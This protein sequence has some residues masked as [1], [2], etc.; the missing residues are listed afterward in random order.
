MV[1]NRWVAPDVC[2]LPTGERPLRQ[3]EFD[4]LF[5]SSVIDVDRIATTQLRLVLEGPA[6]LAE[7][8]QD[9]AD[10]ETSCCSFFTFS[11]SPADHDG[12]TARARRLYLDIKVPAERADVLDGLADRARAISKVRT[13]P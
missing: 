6:G 7:R 12:G 3:A 8:V 13:M 2:T 1:E 9:L 5:V 4:A 11:L 10:R